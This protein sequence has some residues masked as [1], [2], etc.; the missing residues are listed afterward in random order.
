MQSR[1]DQQCL[2]IS[3]YQHRLLQ[4]SVLLAKQKETCFQAGSY[5]YKDTLVDLPCVAYVWQA[6]KTNKKLLNSGESMEIF[7]DML[8]D[9]EFLSK[10][11]DSTSLKLLALCFTTLALL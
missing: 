9:Q 11:G 3:K 10:T 7:G 8:T 5:F 1:L 2:Y 4:N 6:T